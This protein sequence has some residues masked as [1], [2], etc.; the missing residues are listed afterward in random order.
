M[1][2]SIVVAAYNVEAFIERTL[3]SLLC[4]R[5]K[6]FEIIVVND[7]AS[8][9]TERLICQ[10]LE[11]QNDI[12]YKVILKENGGVSSAR[13][14]GL[15]EASGD[16]VLF[17]DGDDYVADNLTI[18]FL[19]ACS[20]E[21]AKGSVQADVICWGYRTVDE[22]G[23]LLK[24]YFESYRTIPASI[25]GTEA[26]KNVF[27][28]K[29]M[30]ICTGSAAY[31]K[32]FLDQNQ[33]Q[34]TEGCSNGEDQEFMAKALAKAKGVTFINESLLFYVQRKDSVSFS[35]N[36][37]K[38]D[39]IDAMERIVHSLGTDRNLELLEIAIEVRTRLLVE[40]YFNSLDSCI[41]GWKIR[42]ILNELDQLYPNL[43]RKIVRSLRR[44][45]R[46]GKGFDR[47]RIK[48]RLYLIHPELYAAIVSLKR[49]AAKRNQN[50]LYRNLKSCEEHRISGSPGGCCR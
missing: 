2:L 12:E 37:R 38:F 46:E 47:Y 7:G 13:N 28:H 17:L 15:A 3:R 45:R 10:V 24:D 39:A 25:T 30:W 21:E 18:R 40:N 35:R 9:G 29:S 4:Q 49:W 6:Q 34:Y 26:L 48:C 19:E 14:R 20:L 41:E 11:N 33:L 23:S 1:K 50:R 36:V 42:P 8:D 5:D 22:N 43:E 27:L 32:Q 31:R 16:Y 44:Y